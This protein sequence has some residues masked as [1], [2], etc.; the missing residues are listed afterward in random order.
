[1]AG[2]RIEKREAGEKGSLWSDVRE[3][4]GGQSSLGFGYRSRFSWKR[5]NSA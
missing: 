2:L 4:L 1:M 3:V 5:S